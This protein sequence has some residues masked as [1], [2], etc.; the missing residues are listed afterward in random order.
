MVDKGKVMNALTHC[1]L[2]N[3]GVSIH[4]CEGCP[5]QGSYDCADKMKSDCLELLKELEPVV[6]CRDCKWNSGT[7]SKPFCMMESM[8]SQEDWFCANGER[9]KLSC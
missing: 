7:P 4:P 9:K 2:L 8:P 5:Y 3:D 6:H 1:M